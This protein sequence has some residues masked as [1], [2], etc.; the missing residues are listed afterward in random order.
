MGKT[1]L[2]FRNLNF[3]LLAAFFVLVFSV[4]TK[5]S[6]ENTFPEIMTGNTTLT[7]G[8]Q[9]N[10]G[11]LAGNYVIYQNNADTGFGFNTYRLK[12]SPPG[13]CI[14]SPLFPCFKLGTGSLGDGAIPNDKN[15]LL[16]TSATTIN[17]TA[18]Y[19]LPVLLFSGLNIN[20]DV[21][22][23]LGYLLKFM[24]L[25]NLYK[26]GDSTEGNAWNLG[27]T[28]TF[29]PDAQVMLGSSQFAQYRSKLDGLADS[30][31]LVSEVLFSSKSSYMLQANN[32]TNLFLPT[33]TLDVANNPDGKVWV[34]NN[35]DLVIDN[36]AKFNGVG[37]IIING[38]NLTVKSGKDIQPGVTSGSRLGIIVL[39]KSNNSAGNCNFEGGGNE[40]NAMVYCEGK[41]TV[42][43]NAEFKGSFVASDFTISSGSVLFSYDPA[44]DTSQPPGFRTL[45]MPHPEEIGNQ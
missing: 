15:D 33:A 36:S 29:N 5:V 23:D 19:Q 18:A 12:A 44:F 20:G 13:S 41:F 38:G 42:S 8:S 45:A 34:V 7:Q 43:G 21:S 31:S 11:G 1:V 16:M 10:Y 32:S 30:G 27:S 26:G 37:T 24:N 4:A 40:I 9:K 28:Y 17:G 25:A 39:K 14:F 2:E 35:Q 6:A 3:L 22:G